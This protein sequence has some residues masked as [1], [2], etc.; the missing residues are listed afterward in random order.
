MKKL[1]I[2][3]HGKKYEHLSTARLKLNCSASY[4]RAM[5]QRGDLV[6]LQVGGSWYI[7]IA[8][9]HRGA[10]RALENRVKKEITLSKLRKNE[11]ETIKNR[12]KTARRLVGGEI[13]LR[14]N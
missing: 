6:C 3:A 2:D 13:R 8:S 12:S 11:L 1:H 14:R 10:R 7:E 5:C 4:V 9:M